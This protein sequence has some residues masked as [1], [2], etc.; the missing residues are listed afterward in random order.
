MGVDMD[1]LHKIAEYIRKKTI[2]DLDSLREGFPGRSDPSFHRDLA[3]LKCATSFTDNSRYYTLPDTPDY[4]GNGL[5]RHGG[6]AFSRNGTAKETV[7]VL[8][9][10]S[11]S[12]L[13]HAELQEMLGIRLYNPLKALVQERAITSVS[14][15][16]KLV[17]FSGDEE[18]GQRQ[19]S[20]RSDVAA[21]I[22]NHPFDLIT[23]IDVLLTVFLEGK[24][25]AESAYRFLKSGKHPNITQN[26]VEEVFAHYKLP[27]K[28]N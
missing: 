3:K 26:E 1:I 24:H 5:W 20:S 22:A 23:V 12:G 2:V 9:R 16:K 6:V 18:A 28:K 15:G 19:R 8:V 11:P 27:G 13:S 21:A 7:R 25:Q 4:D 14:D 17:F 10:E